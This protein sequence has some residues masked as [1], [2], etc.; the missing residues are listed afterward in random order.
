M[1]RFTTKAVVDLVA[2]AEKFPE[3]RDACEKAGSDFFSAFAAALDAYEKT[4]LTDAEKTELAE[5]REAREKAAA[6]VSAWENATPA[7]MKKVIGS[8][9]GLELVQAFGAEL[10]KRAAVVQQI[11][12]RLV[13]L[14]SKKAI[15]ARNAYNEKAGTVTRSVSN[16]DY[17]PSMAYLCEFAREKRLIYVFQYNGHTIL[18]ENK[19][20]LCAGE[21]ADSGTA[22]RRVAHVFVRGHK[23]HKGAE[24]VHAL[25]TDALPLSVVKSGGVGRNGDYVKSTGR[26]TSDF[27]SDNAISLED[28]TAAIS[29]FD[30]A[31]SDSDSDN[32]S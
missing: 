2:L 7:A 6:E 29:V 3:L 30:S 25:G 5:K 16:F 1:A 26:P 9:V 22:A 32:D 24:G 18:V 20:V 19:K 28:V 17:D 15:A 8:K 14:T 11:D 31:R 4:E 10:E 27:L 12:A 21:G 23:D 13:E